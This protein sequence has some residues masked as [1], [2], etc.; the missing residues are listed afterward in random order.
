M[1]FF[2]VEFQVTFFTLLFH[3]HQET[4][5]SSSTIK[6]VISAYLRLLKFLLAILIPAYDS[7][8]LAFHMIYSAYKLNKQDDHIQLWC[9]FF[10]NFEPVHCSMSGSNCWFLT[11]IQVSQE[12]GKLVWYFHLFK[13]FLHFVV[14][15]TVKSRWSRNRC[16]SGTPLLSPWSSKCWQS[17]FLFLGLF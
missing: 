5:S 16:L 2:N 17:D 6:V 14:I 9:T 11:C 10:L 8:S 12:T 13:N 15:L 7:S 3:P 1:N 4:F